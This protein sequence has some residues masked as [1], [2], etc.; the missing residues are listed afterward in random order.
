MLFKANS[1]CF[2]AA[3]KTSL[4][5]SKMLFSV[6]RYSNFCIFPALSALSRFKGQMKVEQFMIL[7]IDLHKL[8]DVI[9]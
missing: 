7:L 1:M 6:S 5:S 9:F 3:L 8:T 4:I 2:F